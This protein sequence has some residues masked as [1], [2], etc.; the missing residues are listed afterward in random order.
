MK[1][2]FMFCKSEENDRGV[3]R[4]AFLTAISAAIPAAG[5]IAPL[6]AEETPAVSE[7]QAKP[8]I[9]S[10]PVLQNPTSTSITAAWA[11]SSRSTGWIEWGTTKE[12][13][14][15]A[16]NAEFGL[17][18]LEERFLCIPIDGLAPNTTYFYRT[19]TVPVD[20][21]NAYKVIPGEPVYSD[22]YSFTTPGPS[23]D[24]ARFAVMND[25]HENQPTLAALTARLQELNADLTVWNGDLIGDYKNADEIVRSILAPAGAP[26]AVEKPL[27]FTCGNHDHRGIFARKKNKALTPWTQP[28]PKYRA[29]GR[30]F[31]VRQGPLALIGLDTGEDKPD[32]NPIFAGLAEFEPYRRLQAAW[33]AETLESPEIASAP[34]IVAFCHIP[35]FD[36]NSKANPGDIMEQYAAWQRPC[37]KLWGPLFEKH[38]VPLVIAAHMH[39]FRYD[40]PTG[41]RSWAQLVG[42]GPNLEKNATIIFGEVKENKLFVT[43][44][45]LSDRSVL[46]AWNFPPRS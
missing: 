24:S 13:G 30:N 15:N 42:G 8:L 44:E 23:G 26:F 6:S 38:H 19:A 3:G 41:E 40:E 34:F 17:R 12:L 11:V 46:G 43:A 7:S 31:A 29:L 35:L 36:S 9:E 25:T 14:Q 39:Q 10:F 2:Y 4:R 1:G 28:N 27:L 45:K 16:Y 18:Q 37:S 32:A 21:Q 22:I 20:F 5:L 33:L